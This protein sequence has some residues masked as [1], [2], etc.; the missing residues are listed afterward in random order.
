MAPV[1][2]GEPQ[3]YKPTLDSFFSV[4]TQQAL[5]LPFQS[6]LRGFKDFKIKGCINAELATR[7]CNDIA[8]PGAT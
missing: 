8:Q 5:L 6:E 7:V 3:H 1:L 4:N 2:S